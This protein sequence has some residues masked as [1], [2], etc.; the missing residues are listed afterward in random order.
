MIKRIV[1]FIISYTYSLLFCL[2]LFTIGFLFAKNR[3]LLFTI[4]AHFG[5]IKKSKV[6]W[7][8]EIIPEVDLAE[9]VQE[10]TPIQLRELVGSDITPSLLEITIIN[11]L[12]KVH[13]PITLFEFGTYNGRTTLNM[14]S[15]CAEKGIVYTLDLPKDPPVS[16]KPETHDVDKSFFD[17]RLVDK[18]IIGSK[19]L[20][21]DY[22]RKI[23][24]LYGDSATF[25]FS[26]FFD[27][28]DFIF[29]DAS[30]Y[31]EYVLNDSRKALK[32]LRNGQGVILWH[33]Y[34][35]HYGQLWEG[36]VEALN[37]LYSE[38]GDFKG[39]RHIKGTT[40]VCLMLE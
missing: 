26:P 33:N 30:H 13:N 34:G 27:T 11:K 23:I 16:T 38:G 12:I 10:N 14:A 36:A 4:C 24:Q 35:P 32:L 21:T 15:N 28:I 9:L 7:A 29:I 17:G 8:L 31:Y 20:G 6:D 3:S 40:L 18:E 37:R 22:E 5:Y 25:D 2:Y 19:Y 39:L 1:T